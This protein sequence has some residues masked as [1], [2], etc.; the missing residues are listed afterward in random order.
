[1]ASLLDP[2]FKNLYFQ[3]KV[4]LSTWIRKFNNEI[5]EEE[6]SSDSDS[7]QLSPAP[8]PSRGTMLLIKLRSKTKLSSPSFIATIPNIVS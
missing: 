1:M 7:G 2:R 8:S 4:M 5:R 3:D 6:E